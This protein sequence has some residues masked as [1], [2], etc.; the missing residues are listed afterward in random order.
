MSTRVRWSRRVLRPRR[1]LHFAGASRGD[2]EKVY[3]HDQDAEN[4]SDISSDDAGKCHA[5][6]GRCRWVFKCPLSGDVTADNAG[7]DEKGEAGEDTENAKDEGA[8]SNGIGL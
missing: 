3:D 2:K 8:D 1:I 4:D 5:G 7:N 6:I